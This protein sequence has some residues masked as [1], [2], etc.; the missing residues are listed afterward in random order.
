MDCGSTYIKMCEKAVEIQRKW[1]LHDT[2]GD[3]A[4]PTKT[5]KNYHGFWDLEA[6]EVCVVGNDGVYD[7]NIATPEDIEDTGA[8][9]LPRQDQLQAMLTKERQN[10]D[11]VLFLF[12]KFCSFDNSGGIGKRENLFNQPFVDSFGSMEQLW[13]AFV[14][15]ECFNRIWVQNEWQIIK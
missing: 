9:W 2:E 7:L 12:W 10:W 11:D 4:V 8:I 13:L 15:K 5:I 14:M 3:Y 6:G 1:L